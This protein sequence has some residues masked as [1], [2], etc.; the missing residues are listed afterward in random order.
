M[1][2]KLI[3]FILFF[4]YSLNVSSRNDLNEVE[5]EKVFKVTALTKNFSKAERSEALS[6]GAGTVKKFGKNAFSQH[7]NNLS[8]EQRQDFLIGNGFF[9][10]VWIASPAS[11]TASDG[12]G[13]LYNARACQSCHIKDG[14]GHLPGEEKPLSAVLKVGNYNNI[15]LIPHKVYGKQLQFFAIPGLLSEGSLSINF[16]N[17]NFMKKNLNKVSLKY[18]NYYLNNLNYGSIETSASLSLRISPQVIGVGLLDAIESSDIINKEDKNDNNKDG[19]SGIAR[20]V[21]D[22]KGN[23]KVG[24]FG[25]RASTPNLFVQT[26]TAFMHD[27]GLSNSV[28]VNAFG[29]CTNDQKKCYKFPNGVNINSSHEVTDEVMEKIVFYLSSLSPPRRRNVSDKDVLYGKKIF[30]ESK[31]TTC[32]TPKYVTSKNAKHDFLKYQLIWP[33]TDL[34]LHD[35]GDELAD[36]DINGNITNKEWKTPPLWGIGYAKEV[37]SRAT[38]LHDG[39]ANTLLEAVLW[40]SGEA[41]NS[42]DFLLKNYKNDLNKLVIFLKSL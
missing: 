42:I 17:S 21:T 8:F 36:L 16:K 20:L 19:I 15:N 26:G 34:L 14:R 38:F 32:H 40:H 5:R 31:C 4:F 1:V 25:V 12:L 28:G 10:K 3:C 24:R 23:K 27:M 39:R 13:P 30:Y 7:F 33:Y 2:L 22:N 11:T 37:N 9:R 35:M 29:D 18:P 6:G 41:K